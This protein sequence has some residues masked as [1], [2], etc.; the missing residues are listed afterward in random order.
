MLV[1]D[2]EASRASLRMILQKG[3]CTVVPV[4]SVSEAQQQFADHGPDN[5]D[6]VVSDYWMPGQTGLDLVDWLKVKDP[7]L[8]VIIVAG[9]FESDLVADSLRRG[10]SDFLAKPIDALR[11]LVAI[12]KAV[13]QTG[14]QRR[15]SLSASAVEDLGRTQMWMVQSGGRMVGNS[16]LDIYFQPKLGAGG[17]FLGHFQVSPEKF[18]CLLTDVS[19]HDLQAAYVSA[20][21]HGVFRGMVMRSATLPEVF[22]YFNDFLVNEWN[23]PGQLQSR[24]S[25]GTSLAAVALLIDTHQ[26]L[27]RVFI[28]GAPAPVYVSP[29]GRTQHMSENDGP[30]LGWFPGVV[31]HAAT[32]AINGG[33]T[34]YLWTDGLADLAMAQSVDPFCLALALQRARDLPGGHL[35][36]RDAGDD[37]LFAAIQLPPNDPATGHFQPVIVENY[38]GDQGGEIDALEAGWRRNFRLAVPGISESAEHD[39]LLATREAMLNAFKHGCA[40]RAEKLVRFQVS[41][42]TVRNVFRVWVEDAGGGHEFDFSAHVKNKGADIMDAHRGLFFIVNLAQTVQFE[43]NGASVIMEFQL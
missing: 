29:D 36:L 6:C 20:Y 9:E 19:G 41:Y 10:V 2:D 22:G 37:I 42:Q 17:D 40:G 15:Q 25:F 4:E 21:F 14:Q 34:I 3:G 23:E 33:G 31:A 30:P 8:S 35:L 13:G 18:C 11:L 27:A 26:Q 7:S 16:F 5:F 28:S 39:I 1:E 24:N 38:R 32:Y 43:R 12:T